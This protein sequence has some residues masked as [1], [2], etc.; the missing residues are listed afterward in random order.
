MA[1][2]NEPALVTFT[3]KVTENAGRKIYSIELMEL[4]K[5]RGQSAGGSS[6]ASPSHLYF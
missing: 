3:V 1:E 5:S 2:N 4:K 6:K